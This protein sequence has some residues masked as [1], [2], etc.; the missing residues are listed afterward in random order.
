MFI[1]LWLA[2]GLIFVLSMSIIYVVST[3]PPKPKWE[4][5]YPRLGKF[6]NGAVVTDGDREFLETHAPF[7]MIKFSPPN[8][9]GKVIG[10]LVN[11]R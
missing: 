7:G 8:G 11:E 6:K 3:P 4:A 9:E 1:E 2:L 5:V 10:R